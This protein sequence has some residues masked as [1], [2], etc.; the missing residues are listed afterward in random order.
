M[1]DLP[2]ASAALDDV[3]SAVAAGVTVLDALPGRLPDA[4]LP[5]FINGRMAARL[6]ARMAGTLAGL[7]VDLAASL[8]DAIGIRIEQDVSKSIDRRARFRLVDTYG[9]DPSAI[10]AAAA[11]EANFGGLPRVLEAVGSD[12]AIVIRSAHLLTEPWAGPALWA[13]RER[14]GADDPPQLLLETRP[15]LKELTRPDAAFFGAARLRLP[16]PD[17]RAW[18]LRDGR[19]LP[20]WLWDAADGHPGLIIEVL[21]RND[22][23]PGAGWRDAVAARRA[24]LDAHFEAARAAHRLG[25]RLLRAIAQGA[26]P[27][28]AVV[29]ARPALVA[30]ALTQLQRHDLVY[31]PAPRTWRLADPALSEA[32]RIDRPH[33]E[34]LGA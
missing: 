10:L 20:A 23:D 22:H 34:A 3:R 12:C 15:W 4:W 24:T 29:D 8:L 13:L 14:V 27:Y 5:T 26:P 33:G 9:P 28:R 18:Q 1:A 30:R 32:L 31:R 11:G 21:E 6:D 17:P 2:I 25:P 19:P 7:V 16:A